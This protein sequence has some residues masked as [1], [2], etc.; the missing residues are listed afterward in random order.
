MVLRL[1]RRDQGL[2]SKDKAK[3]GFMQKVQ[4]QHG[5]GAWVWLGCRLFPRFR[6]NDAGVESICPRPRDKNGHGGLRC[7]LWN[8]LSI[9]AVIRRG[10]LPWQG[11]QEPSCL[12]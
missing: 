12:P 1:G 5:F 8:S 2:L 3:A 6:R 11:L 9:G 4:N 10:D 7:K